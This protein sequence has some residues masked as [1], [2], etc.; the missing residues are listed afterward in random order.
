MPRVAGARRRQ[1]GSP[2]AAPSGTRLGD[3]SPS[4]PLSRR[5]AHRD[6]GCGSRTPLR[7]AYAQPVV[8]PAGYSGRH[9][10]TAAGPVVGDR[11]RRRGRRSRCP[12]RPAPVP[13][14]AP[15][16][17]RD[18]RECTGGFG[19]GDKFS[20]VSVRASRPRSARHSGSSPGQ[21]LS[22]R[23]GGLASS[24]R[25][26][27]SSGAALTPAPNVLMPRCEGESPSL[28][29]REGPPRHRRRAAPTPPLPRG[30][31]PQ[32]GRRP[33]RRLVRGVALESDPLAARPSPGATT[34]RCRGAGLA[35]LSPWERGR[36]G[37]I[38]ATGGERDG[39][40]GWQRTSRR[41]HPPTV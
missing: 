15:R 40:R 32:H 8:L 25:A 36:A 5:P 35:I 14:A 26:D 7:C 21:A 41:R 16:Q 4:V 6:S 12:R 22:M 38:V 11:D 3:L 17:D 39:G 2:K 10:G 18:G 27:H 30:R 24:R 23:G 29:A 28:E 1:S 33:M 9:P 34:L 19:R 20:G 13:G 37:L 31:I